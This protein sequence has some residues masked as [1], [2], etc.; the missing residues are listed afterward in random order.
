MENQQAEKD[1][2]I[3]VDD[4]KSA[5]SLSEL[6]ELLTRAMAGRTI[7]AL[8]KDRNLQQIIDLVIRQSANELQPLLAAAILGRLAAVAHK[9]REHHIYERTNEL[10]TTEPP[11]LAS[12]TDSDGKQKQYVAQ[13]LGYVTSNWVADYRYR[14]ALAIDTA[15]KARRELLAA[16]LDNEQSIS[17]WLAAISRHA[18]ELRTIRNDD[19]RINRVRRIF[20]ALRE[21]TANWRGDIGDDAGRTLANTLKAFLGGKNSDLN[22]DDLFN[23]VDHL[24]AILVRI[25]EVR[26]SNALQ[27]STYRVLEQGRRSISAGRWNRFLSASSQLPQV[28]MALLEAALVLARQNRTDQQILAAMNAAYSSRPQ[29]T[30][31]VKRH[32]SV[33]RDLDPEVADWWCSAGEASGSQRQIDHKMGNTEDH[34]IGA[35][36]IE[37]ESHREAMETLGDFVASYLEISEPVLASTVKKAAAGYQNIAQ[38]ARRLARMRKLNK[39]D[40][41]GAHLDYNP[42]EHEMLGGHQAG[43]RK[44]R[45]LRDGIKKDFNGKIKTLVKP[46]V[47]PAPGAD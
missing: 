13:I 42:L 33:A 46:W 30:A 39:M 36:L 5:S 26:Y 19:S 1:R 20:E 45:V 29:L 41:Q 47:E 38:I 40:V 3:T 34:Q 18:S 7:Q 32:F 2:L 16:N 17:N 24:L 22:Q 37:V 6:N 25:I 9:T 14:E 21:V 27:A 4:L 12:L 11:P 35:L 31:A 28:R 8:I 10:F 44:V 43:V 23:S 15:E